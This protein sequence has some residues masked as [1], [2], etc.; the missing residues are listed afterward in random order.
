MGQVAVWLIRLYQRLFRFLPPVCRF[1]PS[2]SQYT[3]EAIQLHGLLRGMALG[4][5][6]ILRCNPLCK[7]G[8]DAVPPPQDRSQC[9]E[10]HSSENGL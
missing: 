4:A 2:C 5:W 1:Q 7:G 8:V 6:R 9:R 3:L 10:H